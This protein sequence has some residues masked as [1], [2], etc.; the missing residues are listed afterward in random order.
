M[1]LKDMYFTGNAMHVLT[2]KQKWR[3]ISSSISNIQ[4]MV[5]TRSAEMVK[6]KSISFLVT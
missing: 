3:L 2:D 5:R 6:D 1:S 4:G